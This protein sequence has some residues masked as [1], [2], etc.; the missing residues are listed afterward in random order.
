LPLITLKTVV[1]VKCILRGHSDP[2][3]GCRD[4][5]EI[6]AVDAVATH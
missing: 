2:A 6:L 5:I 4:P 3:G 1:P